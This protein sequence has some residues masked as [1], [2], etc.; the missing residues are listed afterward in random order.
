MLGDKLPLDVG[1]RKPDLGIEPDAHAKLAGMRADGQEHL[2]PPVG[3]ERRIVGK[4]SV[5]WPTRRK[6]DDDQVPDATVAI[7]FHLSFQALGLECIPA[8]PPE[9]TR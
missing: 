3:H 9:G 8:P 6:I 4:V 7:T 2:P 5:K 1:A